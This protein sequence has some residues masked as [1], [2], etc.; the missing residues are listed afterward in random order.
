MAEDSNFFDLVGAT[1]RLWWRELIPLTLLNILWFAFQLPLVTAPLATAVVYVI[2]RKV[3]ADEFISVRDAWPAVRLIAIPAL[4]WGAANLVVALVV[5]GNFWLYQSEVG[6]MWAAARITW[7]AVGLG[8]FIV[9]LF[10]WPF[11]LAAEEPRWWSTLRNS[12]LFVVRRP[13]LGFGVGLVSILTFIGSLLLT[14][15]FVVLAMT[16]VALLGLLSVESELKAV[17]AGK[18]V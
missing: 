8:W 15:P 17:R 13:V 7:A 18:G 1:F 3:V 4:V 14:L 16:W 12:A 10:Y 5:V 2:A 6:P 11:W 9:N